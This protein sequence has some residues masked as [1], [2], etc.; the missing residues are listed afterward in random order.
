MLDPVIARNSCPRI[1]PIAILRRMSDSLSETVA[2]LKLTAALAI[3]SEVFASRCSSSISSFLLLMSAVREAYLA[4][5]SPD[6]APPRAST[7]SISSLASCQALA[8]ASTC[9]AIKSL[10]R[11]VPFKNIVFRGIRRVH[12]ATKLRG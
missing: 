12:S 11:F 1:S 8:L 5:S 6:Q 7:E 2:S 9:L 3:A 4:S 10:I